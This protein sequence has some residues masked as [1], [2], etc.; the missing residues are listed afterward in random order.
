MSLS[1]VRPMTIDDRSRENSCPVI[2]SVI[3][4]RPGG[5]TATGRS[6]VLVTGRVPGWGRDGNIGGGSGNSAGLVATLVSASVP[7]DTA[8]RLPAAGGCAGAPG[9]PAGGVGGSTLIWF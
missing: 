2:G 4:S 6:I 1:R 9:A 3:T 7:G 8:G 5:P